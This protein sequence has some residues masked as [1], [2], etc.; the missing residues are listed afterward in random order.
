MASIGFRTRRLRAIIRAR[1]EQIRESNK[2]TQTT[3][4]LIL[5]EQLYAQDQTKAIVLNRR[6]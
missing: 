4:V 6:I 2:N 1:S 5:L 3:Y